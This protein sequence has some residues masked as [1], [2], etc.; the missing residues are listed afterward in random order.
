LKIGTWG[1]KETPTDNRS[2]CRRC[3]DRI[4]GVGADTADVPP[5]STVSAGPVRTRRQVVHGEL[6]DS[7]L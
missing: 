7:P 2:H 4:T 6:E 1:R 3:C 5:G